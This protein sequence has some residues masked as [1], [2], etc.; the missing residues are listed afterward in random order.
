M[1]YPTRRDGRRRARAGAHQ[2][3]LAAAVLPA[4]AF[5]A[6]LRAHAAPA[7]AETADRRADVGPLRRRC[8]RGTVE[9][10]LPN[11]DVYITEWSDARMVPLAEGRF[12]LDDYIDYRHLHAARARRRR[13]RDRGVPAFGAGDGGGGADGGRQGSLRSAFHGA[14]G[15]AD[16]HP[17]QPQRRQQTGRGARH[18]LVPHQRHHQGAVPASR[19]HARR[20]S[21]L[22]AV[23]RLRQHEPR[24][25]YRGAPQ[26][27]HAIWSRA[28]AIRRRSTAN[29][30]TNISRSWISPPSSIC[31]RSIP[32][33]SATRCRKAR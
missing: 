19:R 12:D 29:S 30:T 24:P 13:A 5:R 11:H 16:R 2:L 7:A 23:A 33:S 25:P 18:Q 21:G 9:T 8:L 1:A 3:R 10:F 31:R 32:C 20:L 6:R 14:D 22:F 17:R 28:T 15:R 26:S 4:P 27:V